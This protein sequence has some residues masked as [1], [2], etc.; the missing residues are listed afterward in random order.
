MYYNCSEY[1][2]PES[3]TSFLQ[4]YPQLVVPLK[5]VNAVT[6]LVGTTLYLERYNSVRIRETQNSYKSHSAKLWHTTG[7]Y[8]YCC[9][10]LLGRAVERCAS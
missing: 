7:H 8:G 2:P 9:Q 5:T 6:V 4:D 1:V 10:A 3:D